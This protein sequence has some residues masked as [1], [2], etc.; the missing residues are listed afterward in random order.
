MDFRKILSDYSPKPVGETRRYAVL[1]PLVWNETSQA[2]E[3]LYQVRS[4][5]ISQPGEVA[6]PGGRMEPG[7][8]F[9]ETAIRET[10]EELNIASQDIEVLGEIDYFIYNG[11]TI[12]CF[13]GI[14][15]VD[16][17]ELAP[18]ADEVDHL[19]T[20]ALED[21]LATEPQ[22]YHLT[23]KGR[24]SKDFPF[25]RLPQGQDYEFGQD[26]RSILFY[27]LAGENLWGMTAQFTYNFVEIVRAYAER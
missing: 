22:S 15:K 14:L 2:W 19:F 10:T 11:R 3:V 13:V 16:W 4:H 9:E 17:Q 24:P 20:I 8:T 26:K 7:E 23:A 5:K 18:N 25:D 21:L 1:L 27:N 12:H 6:F